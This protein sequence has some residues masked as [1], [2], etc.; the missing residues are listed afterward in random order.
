MA[1]TTL[2]D[3][4]RVRHRLVESKHAS[5]DANNQDD[6][7]RLRGRAPGVA[8]AVEEVHMCR[9]MTVHGCYY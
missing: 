4:N 6:P 3:L 7:R 9:Y 8:V 5:R 1:T 2:L